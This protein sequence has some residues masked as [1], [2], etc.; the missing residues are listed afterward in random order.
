MLV[1]IVMKE[2]GIKKLFT[3]KPRFAVITYDYENKYNPKMP[4]EVPVYEKTTQFLPYDK[5]SFLKQNPSR[6]GFIDSLGRYHWVSRRNVKELIQK[7]RK[8]FCIDQSN[9]LGK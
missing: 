6:Y 4:T 3:R 5:D 2:A 8:D 1:S 7:Y 9:K